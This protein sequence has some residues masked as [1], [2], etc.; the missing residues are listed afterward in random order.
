MQC[1]RYADKW[2]SLDVNTLIM[3]HLSRFQNFLKLFHS[4]SYCEPYENKKINTVGYATTKEC[5]IKQFLSI[6]PGC[7]NEQMLYQ[8]VLSIK[9]G[10]YNEQMLYKTVFINKT[11]MLQ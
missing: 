5:Y 3:D 2:E 7:Y 1:P 10:C 11:T 6:K 8:T 9:S 4:V